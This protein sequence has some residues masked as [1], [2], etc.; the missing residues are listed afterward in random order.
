MPANIEIK[1]QAGDF[2]TQSAIAEEIADGPASE[3]HQTDTFFN[4]P[5]G[6]LKLRE[7][8]DGSGEL[9]Q[10]HR[11]DA[12]GPKASSYVIL[13]VAEP[14]TLKEALAAALGVRSVVKKIRRVW[15]TGKTRMHFDRVEGLGE[16][17]ELEVVLDEQ[18]DAEGGQEIA[19]A[20]MKRLGIASADLV[21]GA[22]VDLLLTRAGIADR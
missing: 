12:S 8:G 5:S 13:P 14:A 9:I 16:F 11:P 19:E 18:L 22:Y 21:S 10:Y 2:A 7:F 1:A 4:V 15:L 3:L 17:I 20:L 6:R